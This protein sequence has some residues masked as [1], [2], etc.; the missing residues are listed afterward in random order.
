LATEL[1]VLLVLALALLIVGIW[2]PFSRQTQLLPR[3]MSRNL[4]V[5][6]VSLLL[7]TAVSLLGEGTGWLDGLIGSVTSFDEA[8]TLYFLSLQALALIPVLAAIGWIRSDGAWSPRLGYAGRPANRANRRWA[9]DEGSNRPRSTIWTGIGVAV[10]LVPLASGLWITSTEVPGYLNGIVGKTSNVTSG[11]VAALRWVGDHLP[12]CSN[13]LAGPGSA[14][15]FL[16]E[17]AQVHLVFQ[18]NPTPLN[19]S[20]NLVVENLTDGEYT[21]QTRTALEWLGVTEIFVTG[22]TSVSFL[23]LQSAPLASSP[24]FTLDFHQDDAYVFAF[25]PGIGSTGCPS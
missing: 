24:D 15:Q 4:A 12:A 2:R 25:V 23:P 13:V 11:D 7:L 21:A 9:L 10:V 17:Y 6:T 8:S 5:T 14:A 3:G 18:M 16:P 1:Q 20:Y 19:G 22:Q